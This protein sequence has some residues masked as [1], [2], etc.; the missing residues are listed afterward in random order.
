[1]VE[2][3]LWHEGRRARRRAVR[4]GG[5]RARSGVRAAGLV[6]HTCRGARAAERHGGARRRARQC[7][8]RVFGRAEG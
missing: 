6:G 3:A 5:A 8:A 4:A 7:A 2:P 1:M